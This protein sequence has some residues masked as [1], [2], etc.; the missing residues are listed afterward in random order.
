MKFPDFFQTGLAAFLLTLCSHSLF[1]ADELFI[2][3]NFNS[4]STGGGAEVPRGYATGDLGATA[5][6]SYKEAGGDGS[7]AMDLSV[8]FTNSQGGTH[9][10]IAYVNEDVVGNVSTKRSEYFLEFEAKG[11][12]PD[13]EFVMTIEGRSGPHFQGVSTGSLK[14]VFKLPRTAEEPQTYRVALDDSSFEGEF[15]T[16]GQTLQITFAI[17][18]THW[19]EGSNEFVIDNI[20]LGRIPAH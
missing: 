6:R 18:G 1:A 2:D 12:K 19:N 3:E 8:E 17:F 15:D 10:T 16:P 9:A 7:L 20:K 13:G 5:E 11:T 4:R 14:H